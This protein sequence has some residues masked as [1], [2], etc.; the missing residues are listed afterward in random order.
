VV[1]L[2]ELPLRQDPAPDASMIVVR[3]VPVDA[4]SLRGECE[5]MARR[6]NHGSQPVLGFSVEGVTSDW[7]LTRVVAEGRVRT[8]PRYTWCRVSEL[9]GVGCRLLASFGTDPPHFTVQVTSAAALEAVA[10]LLTTRIQRNW[11]WKERR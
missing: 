11:A 6:F 8:H 5:R 4:P 1:A 9:N 3:G 7:P 10:E 2:R